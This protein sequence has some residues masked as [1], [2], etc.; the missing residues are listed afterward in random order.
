L[1]ATAT[2]PQCKATIPADSKFCPN[3]GYQMGGEAPAKA[4]EAVPEAGDEK[5]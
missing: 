2:C 3:C 1:S 4:E 5:A